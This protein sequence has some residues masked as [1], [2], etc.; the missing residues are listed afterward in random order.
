VTRRSTVPA[1][2]L[3]LWLASSL[4]G[5]TVVTVGAAEPNLIETD[6]VVY[7]ATPGGILAA[8]TAARAGAEVVLIEPTAHVGGLMTNGLGHTDIGSPP[9]YGGYTREFFDRVQA[10]GGARYDHAPSAAEQAFE[11]MLASTA[12]VVRTGEALAES[13]GVERDGTAITSITTTAD[14]RYEAR[15]FVDASY[16]GDLLAQAGVSYRIGREAVSEFGE[17]LAGAQAGGV[18]IPQVAGRTMPYLTTAP[19]PTGTAD[20]RIQDANYRVCFSS[21]PGN[22]VPFAAPDDYDPEDYEMVQL[23]LAYRSFQQGQPAQLG[24]LLSIV[25]LPGSKYDVNDVGA[26]STAIPGLDWAYPE[27]TYADRATIDQQHRAYTEG[28]F[29]FLA[30]DESVAPTVRDAMAAY[31][32]C[33]DEFLDN[34]HWPRQLYVREGRRMEGAYVLRQSDLVSNRTKSDIIGIASYRIDAHYVSRWIDND[35]LMAEGQMADVRRNYAIPY[36]VM[37]P[38]ASEV[39]NLLV[40]VASSVSHVAWSSLRME[41]QF[42]LMGEAAGE[43][44]AMAVSPRPPSIRQVRPTSPPRIIPTS[45]PSPSPAPTPTG[46]LPSGGVIPTATPTPIPTPT[47]TPIPTPVPTPT[48]TPAPLRFVEL[49]AINVGAIDIAVLQA[50][51]KAHGAKLTNPP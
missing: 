35:R 33:A 4:V 20:E 1:F 5:G 7:G 22:Q 51:L 3:A 12:V 10:I 32:L 15:V 18:V 29:Y 27:A 39:R 46:P 34:D 17:S 42:M 28:L 2:L 26:V 47:P 9:V 30:N 6:I 25:P 43:A 11:E 45:P 21:E 48:P 23:F 31:G 44:A 38:Q 16:M 19:G 49:A 24:W 50:R 41:P 40:P 13:D 36:R 8:V 14:V 37:V